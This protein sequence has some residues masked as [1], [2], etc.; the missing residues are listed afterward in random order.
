MDITFL[1]DMEQALGWKGGKLLIYILGNGGTGPSQYIDDLQGVNN[2][3]APEAWKIY[4]LWYEHSWD[5]SSLLTGLYD[6]NS[7]FDIIKSAA[8]F[9][10]PS[11]GIG[12][13]F[14]Q[15]GINGPSIFPTTSFGFR[16]FTEF[17]ERAF[18]R[19]T[20]LDGVPGDPFQNQ[21]THIH[22]TTK[23]GLLISMEAG[24]GY[25]S[26]EHNKLAVGG[27]I[28]T[29]PKT[30][31]AL[32][33]SIS[34]QQNLGFYAFTEKQF[35][36]EAADARQGWMG[37]VRLGIADPV[38]NVIGSYVGLGVNYYGAFSDNSEDQFGIGM[39]KAN[40]AGPYRTATGSDASE[41]A[42]EISYRKKINSYLT[43]TPDLQYIVNP[44]AD[45]ANID[46][47]VISVRFE[48]SYSL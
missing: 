45:P 24:S 32:D 15:S 26:S 16:Y 38:L 34:P 30:V 36:R 8:V 22:L 14:A 44:G 6:L 17:G 18:Y 21:A 27:W 46:A 25:G 2:I 29:K 40:V 12:P 3:E 41:T 11:F 9:L 35:T 4:E 43:V 39:A 7:E 5:D 10:H 1:G 13:D 37:F 47:T 20:V 48:L 23:E 33:N 31:D 19:V 28:Y 42:F